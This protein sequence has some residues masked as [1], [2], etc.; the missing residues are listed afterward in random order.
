M[1]QYSQVTKSHTF[2]GFAKLVFWLHVARTGNPD[3]PQ[4]HPIASSLQSHNLTMKFKLPR[5][6]EKGSNAWCFLAPVALVIFSP[7]IISLK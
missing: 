3:R 2:Q 5:K 7:E 4:A 1:S 6:S